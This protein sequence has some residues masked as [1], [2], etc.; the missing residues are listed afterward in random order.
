MVTNLS[1]SKKH[2]QKELRNAYNSCL[3]ENHPLMILLANNTAVDLLDTRNGHIQS[4]FS[5]NSERLFNDYSLP[6]EDRIL[7]FTPGCRKNVNYILLN[8]CFFYLF[9]GMSDI[10]FLILRSRIWP[11]NQVYLFGIIVLETNLCQ[12]QDI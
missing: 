8:N 1:Y 12:K 3:Y 2:Y 4:L 7:S 10:Y 9:N 5:I 6:M 11:L